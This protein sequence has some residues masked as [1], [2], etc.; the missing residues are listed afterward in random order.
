MPRL[1]RADAASD[2]G[3]LLRHLA[4]QINRAAS[5]YGNHQS[6]PGFVMYGRSVIQRHSAR[7]STIKREPASAIKQVMAMPLHRRFRQ[8]LSQ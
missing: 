5:F 8:L 6:P 3:L 2:F 7:H 4:S 1:Q